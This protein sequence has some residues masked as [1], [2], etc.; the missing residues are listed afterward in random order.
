MS[1]LGSSTHK[2][3]MP[4]NP[5]K[6]SCKDATKLVRIAGTPQSGLD[7]GEVQQKL[8]SATG[9]R[10]W[11]SLEEL[12]EAPAF[13]EL[14]H[15]EFPR[16]ASEWNDGVSRRDFLKLASASLALAGLSGCTK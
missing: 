13:E 3:G 16:L 8:A 7:L 2:A 14:L 6:P 10:Y 5:E 15:R 12:A 4:I 1:S 9:P 11:R